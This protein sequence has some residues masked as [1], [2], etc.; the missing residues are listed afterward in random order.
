VSEVKNNHELWRND[1]SLYQAY[2]TYVV[3]FRM[4]FGMEVSPPTYDEYVTYYQHSQS[5]NQP[6]N[7]LENRDTQVEKENSKGSAPSTKAK[8][9]RWEADQAQALVSSW[10]DYFNLVESHKSNSRWVK[11]QLEVNRVG[12]Y[13]S[14]KQCK[15]KLR[16]LKD[17]YKAACDNNKQSGA[18][19]K[20]F[21]QFIEMFEEI[22][23]TRDVINMPHM[24]DSG[25]TTP[26]PGKDQP[27]PG[28]DQPQPGKDFENV[29]NE[30][31]INLLN[32]FAYEKEKVVVTPKQLKKSVKN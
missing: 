12:P 20:L 8:R 32:E 2:E 3:N 27:Q 30:D 28:K 10:R 25:N 9:E 6:Q 22:Y 16:N 19:S 4:Q 31:E 24:L 13:K 5:Q 7:T 15:D 18:E 17:A 26:K 21:S 14:L 1:S 23:G 11:I 29:I